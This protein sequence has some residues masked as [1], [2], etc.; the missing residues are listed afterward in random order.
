MEDGGVLENKGEELQL[1]IKGIVGIV[2]NAGTVDA[3]HAKVSHLGEFLDKWTNLKI[4]LSQRPPTSWSRSKIKSKNIMAKH[5]Q[6][7]LEIS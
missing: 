4:S 2:V 1:L 5:I 7:R 3:L 6:G